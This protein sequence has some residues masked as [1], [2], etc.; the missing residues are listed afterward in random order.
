MLGLSRG[1]G[2][3]TSVGVASKCNRLY[4]IR[5]ISFAGVFHHTVEMAQVFLFETNDYL[6]ERKSFLMFVGHIRVCAIFRLQH[7]KSV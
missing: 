1:P 7:L 2:F 4:R 3:V 6:S 5:L